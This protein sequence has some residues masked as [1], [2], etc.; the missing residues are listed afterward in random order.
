MAIILV[1]F[2]VI[3]IIAYFL[4]FK[5]KHR[6]VS[7]VASYRANPQTVEIFYLPHPPAEAIVRK[8]EPIIAEF[9]KFTVKEF[10]FDDPQAKS[11][12]DKYNLTEHMPIAIF[13]DGKDVFTLGDKSIELK[14]FPKDDAFAPSYEGGWSYEN[15]RAILKTL[16]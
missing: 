13:I 6:L 2:C 10:S 7:N 3:G 16:N 15:L 12:I 5:Q 4:V 14:N 9:P 11:L 8:V 1:L